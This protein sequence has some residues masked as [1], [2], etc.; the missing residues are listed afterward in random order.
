[1]ASERKAIS[2]EKR[3]EHPMARVIFKYRVYEYPK[4]TEIPEGGKVLSIGTQVLNG[5]NVV[6]A[7]V[8]V[9]P[10]NRLVKRKICFVFTSAETPP[11]KFIGTATTPNGLVVHVFDDGET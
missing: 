5:S 7:W 11:G 2:S 3:K 4:T 9:E 6:V 8:D 10:S 1:M